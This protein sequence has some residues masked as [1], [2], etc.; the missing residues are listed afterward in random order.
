MSPKRY[1]KKALSNYFAM[2]NELPKNNVWTPLERGDHPELDVTQE[3]NMEEVKKY[4]S[5]LGALQWLVS[6]GRFNIATAVTTLSKYRIA[7]RIGHMNRA[8]RIFAYLSRFKE[9]T[10]R[11][12]TTSPDFSMMENIVYD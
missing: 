9:G 7:P 1:V 5:L 3:L 8:K 4:Q 12:R 6:I 2:F 11:F 10:V